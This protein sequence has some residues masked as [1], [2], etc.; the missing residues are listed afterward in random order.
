M[1]VSRPD[2]SSD[3]VTA[4]PKSLIQAAHSIHPNWT[5]IPYVSRTCFSYILVGV[6]PHPLKSVG[7]CPSQSSKSQPRFFSLSRLQDP[8]SHLFNHSVLTFLF[9]FNIPGLS[10]YHLCELL[11]L[12]TSSLFFTLFQDLPF[13]HENLITS[14][15]LIIF[16]ID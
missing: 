4:P 16:F 1:Y 15:L 14:F 7:E 11:T 5:Y 2:L 6:C 9:Y 3:D 10:T 8:T 12:I 13:W